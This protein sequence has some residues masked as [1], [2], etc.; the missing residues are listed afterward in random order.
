MI[1]GENPLFSET[2]ILKGAEI[3]PLFVASLPDRLNFFQVVRM[4]DGRWLQWPW[5]DCAYWVGRGVSARRMAWHENCR[6]KKRSLCLR[7]SVQWN[8]HWNVEKSPHIVSSFII[9]GYIC[10][11]VMRIYRYTC[12]MHINV[13][14]HI[15]K[16]NFLLTYQKYTPEIS[17]KWWSLQEWY[18]GISPCWIQL[19]EVSVW[20]SHSESHHSILRTKYVEAVH[21]YCSLTVWLTFREMLGGRKVTLDVG[22]TFREQKVGEIVGPRACWKVDWNPF[23]GLSILSLPETNELHLINGWLDDDP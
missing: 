19:F 4:F 23:S 18:I 5:V 10:M 15:R 22:A 14:I 11:N 3:F 2:L 8:R 6:G 13:S 9:V 7:W 12:Q 1:W 16:D 17:P 21:R 20:L